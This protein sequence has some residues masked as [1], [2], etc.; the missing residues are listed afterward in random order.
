MINKNIK[1]ILHQKVCQYLDQVERPS[2]FK[3]KTKMKMKYKKY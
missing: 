2:K 3:K 1:M